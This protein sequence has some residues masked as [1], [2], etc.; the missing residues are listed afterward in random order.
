MKFK[1]L[2]L[3]S[4]FLFVEVHGAYFEDDRVDFFGEF[5]DEQKEEKVKSEVIWE[6]KRAPELTE[7]GSPEKTKSVQELMDKHYG[8]MK[9]YIGSPFARVSLNSDGT[10][11]I[12]MPRKELMEAL[13][14]NDPKVQD[15]MVRAWVADN[16][17]QITAI[18]K[19]GPILKNAAFDMEVFKPE[20]FIVQPSKPDR[21]AELVGNVVSDPAYL[22]T[23]KVA[24][25]ISDKQ[26]LEDGEQVIPGTLQHDV[27]VLYFYDYE[28]PFCN[29]FEPTI[30][31]F[32]TSNEKKMDFKGIYTNPNKRSFVMRVKYK[33]ARGDKL[34]FKSYMFYYDDGQGGQGDYRVD[35][36]IEGTPTVVMI[37][38]IT[39]DVVRVLDSSATL[40]DLNKA[41]N[42]V[43]DNDAS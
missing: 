10:Y 18:N 7:K 34:P 38:T 21:A 13:H 24:K 4:A 35:F 39:G 20:D 9:E 8:W 1:G 43:S 3:M 23:S 40:N 29:D 5:K 27:V 37:N 30:D 11:S 41:L 42:I 17:R 31:K 6:E 22:V 26:N 16:R 28:C 36:D 19:L 32:V 2:A 14:S 15:Q 25:P 12:K 33:Q